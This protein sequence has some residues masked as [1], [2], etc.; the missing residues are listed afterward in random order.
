MKSIGGSMDC[1]IRDTG[2]KS[3]V[4]EYKDSSAKWNEDVKNAV[5]YH[6]VKAM[7]GITFSDYIQSTAER[8]PTEVVADNTGTDCLRDGQ[9]ALLSDADTPRNAKLKNQENKSDVEKKIQC[10]KKSLSN[11]K[12]GHNKQMVKG[13]KVTQR[14]DTFGTIHKNKTANKK[15]PIYCNDCNTTFTSL[16]RFEGHKARN[17]GKCIFPCEYCG[18]VFKYRKSKYLLHIR[19]AH[20]KERPHVCQ[21]CGKGFVTSDKL[22]IHF[23]TH[24]GEKPCVCEQCGRAFYSRADLAIHKN[25]HHTAKENQE[26]MRCD[27][28]SVTFCSK[29]YLMYHKQVTHSEQRDFLCNKCEKRFKSNTALQRHMVY[30]HTENRDYKCKECDKSFK[31]AACLKKHNLRHSG[32]RNFLCNYCEKGFYEKAKLLQHERI[33]TGEK[34]YQCDLCDY[35]CA[36]S[37]NLSK[38]KKTHYRN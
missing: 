27:I 5:I 34:P 17:G 29:R 38:H 25:Y 36:L 33:H 16:K 35:K 24:T 6:A 3:E 28:C 4:A 22:K 14:N 9:Q 31:T 18:K 19:S 30:M 1:V 23:R 21:L 12:K 10:G 11:R 15:H 8:S 20:T 7:N 37:G 26:D 13:A 32:E 2:Q